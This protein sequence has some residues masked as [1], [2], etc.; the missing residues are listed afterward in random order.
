MRLAL[1]ERCQN[2]HCIAVCCLWSCLSSVWSGCWCWPL[3]T[4]GCANNGHICI[5]TGPWQ[6]DVDDWVK[7]ASLTWGIPGIRMHYGDMAS[8]QRQCDALGNVQLRNLGSYHPCECY[9][10]MHQLHRHCCRHPFMEMVFHDGCVLFQTKKDKNK[11]PTEML[12]VIK[13]L[14]GTGGIKAQQKF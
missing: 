12:R 14:T 13:N 6:H 4:T 5:R 8:R 7:C 2:I 3:S 9:F 11:N 10:D 1:M